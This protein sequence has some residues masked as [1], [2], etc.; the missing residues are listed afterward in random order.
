MKT[1]PAKLEAHFNGMIAVDTRPLMKRDRYKAINGVKRTN[2]ESVRVISAGD[3]PPPIKTET[4]TTIDHAGDTTVGTIL[5]GPIDPA[6]VNQNVLGDCWL[7]V[8]ILLILFRDPSYFDDL[9]V[10][11]GDGKVVVQ[12]WSNGLIIQITTSL[13]V[14]TDYDKPV[15]GDIR[16][17]LL[18]KV[19]AFFRNGI[20]D[21]YQLNLGNVVSALAA[22]GLDVGGT[23]V[24]SSAIIA[25]MNAGSVVSLMTTPTAPSPWV[26]DHFYA[27]RAS[28][29]AG[30]LLMRNPWAGSID[31]SPTSPSTVANPAIFN[32]AQTGSFPVRKRLLAAYVQQSPPPATSTTTT[33][34]PLTPS[35]T[36]QEPTMTI[37]ISPTTPT[38][39]P[40][41]SGIPTGMRIESGPSGIPNLGFVD[42]KGAYVDFAVSVIADGAYNLVIP[43]GSIS[44]V[45]SII[46]VNG[47]SVATSS[48]P[49]SGDW[50]RYVSWTYRIALPTGLSTLRIATVPGTQCNFRDLTLTPVGAV[51]PAT[52][53]PAAPVAPSVKTIRSITVNVTYSDGSTESF[54][55]P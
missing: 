26:Q 30:N 41:V 29:A 44:A 12:L 2:I 5:T 15:N 14:S 21:Y 49:A 4:Q 46:S 38:T 34:A 32:G 24:A 45:T 47:Q 40:V 6:A 19:Y 20:S 51:V 13:V 53:T 42:P 33:T 55:R 18:E 1:M 3:A 16:V 9:I 8:A 35:M 50:Q 52:P 25:A 43:I 17:E 22:F 37:A 11:I 23:V 36:P 48:T 28:D 7:L 27:V 10:P 54:S 31:I 39:V